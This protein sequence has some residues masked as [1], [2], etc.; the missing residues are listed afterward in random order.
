MT[1]R[2]AKAVGAMLA[3]TGIDAAR[4]ETIGHGESEP[5][6]DNGTAAGRQQSRRVELTLIGQKL[7]SLQAN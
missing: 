6:A 4:I 5:V 1:E 2:R 3:D 7:S